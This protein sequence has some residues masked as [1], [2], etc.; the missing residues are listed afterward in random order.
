MKN[1]LLI[2][3]LLF[4]S[5]NDIKNSNV[6]NNSIIICLNPCNNFSQKEANKI[7][8]E[9]EDFFYN[10]Y[11]IIPQITVESNIKL[12]SEFR[13]S[14]KT[15]YNASELIKYY[16]T[17]AELIQVL[18]L[19]EDI[20]TYRNN[21]KEWEILGQSIIGGNTCIVSSYRLKNK[22]NMWKV[23]LHEYCHTYFKYYH[24][25]NDD[26]KCFMKDAKGHANIEIQKYFC[27][28]CKK[29]INFK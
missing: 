6:K 24:C 25:P 7:A 12:S 5:C 21:K 8:I 26:P 13:N 2:I 11:K 19:N 18:L 22:N 9:L 23:V 29:I 27:N 16:Q 4:S 15:R 3:L 14:S 28:D 10:N 20:F 17:D 1:I